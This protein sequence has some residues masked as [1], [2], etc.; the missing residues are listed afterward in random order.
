MS[1]MKEYL[2]DVKDTFSI[3]DDLRAADIGQAIIDLNNFLQPYDRQL[4]LNVSNKSLQIITL[5]R[6]KIQ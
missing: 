4:E 3:S 1:R 2:G 5:T 6:E